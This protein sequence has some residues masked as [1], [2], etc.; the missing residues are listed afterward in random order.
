V[1]LGVIAARE[2]RPTE[3]AGS[4]QKAIELD[5]SLGEAHYRLS[6]VYRAMGESEKAKKEVK[7]FQELQKKPH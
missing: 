7:I 6:E 1:K 4:Y 2:G 3:A 5:P